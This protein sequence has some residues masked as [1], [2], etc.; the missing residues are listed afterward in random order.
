MFNKNKKIKKLEKEIS[1]LEE[2][3]LGE[4]EVREIVEKVMEER[5]DEL[6]DVFEEKMKAREETYNFIKER[7]EQIAK[8]YL[9]ELVEEKI[10]DIQDKLLVEL[11]RKAMKMEDK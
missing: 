2:D 11:A 9:Q 3:S 6:R 1:K 4:Y 5:E 10:K 8:V 7:I